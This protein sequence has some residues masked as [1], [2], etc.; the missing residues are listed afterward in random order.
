MGTANRLLN[1][2]YQIGGRLPGKEEV[3]W[4]CFT[5]LLS[6]SSSLFTY[7]E[8]PIKRDRSMS[9]VKW[10]VFTANA[11]EKVSQLTV[12]L[13]RRE[14]TDFWVIL[15]QKSIDIFMEVFRQ[16]TITQQL[17]FKATI[18]SIFFFNILQRWVIFLSFLN[19]F[20][21]L[22]INFLIQSAIQRRVSQSQPLS[23]SRVMHELCTN[24]EKCV[25]QSKFENNSGSY[26]RVMHELKFENK[27]V[28]QSMHKLFYSRE[29]ES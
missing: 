20:L 2:S 22:S 12:I 27:C 1:F 28:S 18:S 21:L 15:C 5:Y 14:Q 26:S 16:V 10:L 17:R 13:F 9:P 6:T 7:W 23:C 29:F 8:R 4:A 24:F 11:I 25:S 3:N 19:I